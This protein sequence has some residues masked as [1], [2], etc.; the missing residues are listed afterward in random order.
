[1]ANT[2]IKRDVEDRLA[3]RVQETKE[4]IAAED[5]ANQS[6]RERAEAFRDK[7]QNSA[8]P[9][10]PAGIIPGFH[11]CWLS[12]TNNYDSIDKRVALGYEPVKAS[13]L[14]KG[15]EGLGKMSSGKFEG[16]VSCNEMVLFKLP[17]EIYQE[18]M[19]MMHLE[20]PLDHQRNITASVR[21]TAQEGKGGRSILD[22]G[23]LELEKEAAKANSNI[24]F[25]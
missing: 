9:D 15:F 11:L 19:R 5:P 13:E 21:N 12:T 16:C 6:K 24:R 3:D 4:R 8:L 1:M 23:H 20:D 22:G 10:L 7:W 25:D 14:G 2:R 17:E 18:V